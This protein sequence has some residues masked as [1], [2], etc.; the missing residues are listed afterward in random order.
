MSGGKVG[1]LQELI[2]VAGQNWVTIQ[3][4]REY[5]ECWVSD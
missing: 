3:D 5:C 1:W 2:G 4:K